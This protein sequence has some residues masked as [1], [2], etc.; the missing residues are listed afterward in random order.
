VGGEQTRVMDTRTLV[1][2]YE[3]DDTGATGRRVGSA[4]LVQPEL[5]VV[6][7]PLCHRLAGADPAPVRLR[8]GI[9]SLPDAGGVE[10]ID[11][12]GTNVAAAADTGSTAPPLV[13]LD[14]A[15]P[16]KAPVESLPA[17]DD[18]ADVLR[19]HLAGVPEQPRWPPRPEPRRAPWCALWPDSWLCA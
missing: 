3:V 17:G 19:A 2:V 16:S 11:T 18:L 13:A 12:R 7:P 4:S 9:V 15:R 1:S 8:V 5:V 14:L 6:H 10:V